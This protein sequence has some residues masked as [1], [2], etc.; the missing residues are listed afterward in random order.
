MIEAFIA[1]E[2]NYCGSF[3]HRSKNGEQIGEPEDTQLPT[4]HLSSNS[5]LVLIYEDCYI[6]PPGRPP[7]PSPRFIYDP[8]LAL[9]VPK[10]SLPPRAARQPGPSV[11]NPRSNPHPI[12]ALAGKLCLPLSPLQSPLHYQSAPSSLISKQISTISRVGYSFQNPV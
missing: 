3:N 9:P 6:T 8:S 2:K 12:S 1:Q 7:A 10:F 11:P 4:H 5:P